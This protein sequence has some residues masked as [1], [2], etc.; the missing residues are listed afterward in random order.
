MLLENSA[1]ISRMRSSIVKFTELLILQLIR[2]QHNMIVGQ[3]DMSPLRQEI[4][5]FVRF[6]DV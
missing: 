2:R 6:C 4:E 5:E 3:L 1:L